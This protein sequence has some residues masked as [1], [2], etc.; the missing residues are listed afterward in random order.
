VLGAAVGGD[1]Q[2]RL[3][4]DLAVAPGA[5]GGVDGRGIEADDDQRGFRSRP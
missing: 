3:V 2:Q 5:D 4:Q 1:P